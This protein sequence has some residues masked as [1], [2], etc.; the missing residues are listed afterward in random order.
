MDEWFKLRWIFVNDRIRDRHQQNPMV[1]CIHLQ[2]VRVRFGEPGSKEPTVAHDQSR[3]LNPGSNRSGAWETVE[4][5]IVHGWMGA[6]APTP[7]SHGAE[8]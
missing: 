4:C 5:L 7:T 8:R 1:A 6:S 3:A 2:D